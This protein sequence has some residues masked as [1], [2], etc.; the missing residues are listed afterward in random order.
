MCDMAMYL[1]YCCILF[2]GMHVWCRYGIRA[3]CWLCSGLYNEHWRLNTEQVYI[4]GKRM[5]WLPSPSPM[6]TVQE[7]STCYYF[8]SFYICRF[9]VVILFSLHC[10]FIRFFFFANID[11]LLNSGY[12]VRWGVRWYHSIRWRSR[13]TTKYLLHHWG[14]TI[15]HTNMAATAIS[16]GRTQ[17]V[18]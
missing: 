11:S 4:N 5:V 1:V 18:H 2:C 10:F 6:Q 16:T 14:S 7:I 15:G 3:E 13:R 12:N 9:L 17:T 8:S